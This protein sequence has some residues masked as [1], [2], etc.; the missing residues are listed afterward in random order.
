MP[1]RLIPVATVAERLGG[2]SPWTVR[3]LIRTRQLGSTRVRRRLFVP[4]SELDR[5]IEQQ[6]TPA[7]GQAK[8]A[9]AV[10]KEDRAAPTRASRVNRLVDIRELCKTEPA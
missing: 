8:A 6:T 2:I 5:Y 10:R 3:D 9:R 4:E 7:S 1:E